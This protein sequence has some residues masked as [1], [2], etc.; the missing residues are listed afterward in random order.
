MSLDTA[1]NKQLERNA[2]LVKEGKRWPLKTGACLAGWHEGS[3]PRCHGEPVKTCDA[4]Q[5]CPCE[6]HTQIDELFQLQGKPREVV[7][8]P[9]YQPKLHAHLFAEECIVPDGIV[10]NQSPGELICLAPGL[11]PA[12]LVR[13]FGTTPSGRFA[14][15]ELEIKVK[16]VVDAWTVE[17]EFSDRDEF[18]SPQIEPCTPPY[19]ANEISKATGTKVAFGGVNSVFNRWKEMDIALFADHPYRLIAYTPAAIEL[20]YDRL[21]ERYERQHKL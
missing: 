18:G 19:V 15:G 17:R 11:V 12:H 7:L 14:R 4:Y 3:R 1:S 6:C 8:N 9:D 20:G 10:V 2:D 21:K 5:L 13:K 16:E